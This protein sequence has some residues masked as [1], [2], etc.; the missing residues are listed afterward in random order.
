MLASRGEIHFWGL[1]A[2]LAG[3]ALV[4]ASAC[5]VNNYIDRGIDQKMARTK[6]RALVK[7][8]ISGRNALIYAGTLGLAGFA[9]LIAYTNL[10][11]VLLGIIAFVVYV[12][13]YGVAKRRTVYGTIVGS[14]SGAMP[15]TAGYTAV[16]GSFDTGALLLFTILVVWQMPHFYAI[17]MY[18]YNDYAQ[19]RLP[20]LP[21]KQGM[22]AAKQHIL[23]YIIVFVLATLAL[24][25]FGYTGYVYAGVMTLLGAA[26]LQ[27][28]TH[29]FKT[30]D[31][32]RWA[33]KMFGFSLLVLLGFSFM[34][35]ITAWLP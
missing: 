10:L 7:G 31:D 5:V 1:V 17:A 34:I 11:T 32:T 18:R 3:V 2:L 23:A 6:N 28:A 35:S 24:T 8:I 29:G 33:R 21:I 13:A 15:I 9:V 16:T 20:V 14:I 4:I 30:P 12:A 27:K 25:A 26:W 19:A 22:R